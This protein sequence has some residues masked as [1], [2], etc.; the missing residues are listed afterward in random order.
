MPNKLNITIVGAGNGGLG[1]AIALAKKGH[2]VTVLE[3]ISKLKEV[4]AGIKYRL[5]QLESCAGTA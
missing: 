4:G 1:A 5:I 2:R 3:A